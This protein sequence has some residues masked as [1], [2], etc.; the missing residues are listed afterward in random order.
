MNDNIIRYLRLC[1]YAN[2]VDGEEFNDVIQELD[3]LWDAFSSE[4]L[5]IVRNFIVSMQVRD[6]HG[7]I[8]RLDWP[9]WILDGQSERNY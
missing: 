5:A 6:E 7:R 8:I 1:W 9:V 3:D 2:Q 4:D